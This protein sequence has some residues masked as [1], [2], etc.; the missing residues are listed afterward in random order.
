MAF[1]AILLPALVGALG[2]ASRASIAA[3]R[4]ANAMQL[5]EN[6]LNEL[7]LDDAWSSGENRGEFGEDWPGYRW[8][9]K[10]AD[11]AQSAEMT[12]LTLTVFYEVRGQEHSVELSTLA[13]TSAEATQ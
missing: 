3:E 1:L 13:T 6:M 10:S 7:M 5:G 9:L 11:W 2:V 4:S 8:E 12:E